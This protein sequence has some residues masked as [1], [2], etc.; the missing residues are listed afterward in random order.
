VLSVKWNQ[1]GVGDTSKR[2]TTDEWGCVW[3]RSEVDNMGQVT[4]HPLSEW[5]SLAAFRWPDHEDPAFYTGMDQRFEGSEGKYVLTPIFMLLFER[6]QAL[7]GFENTMY[8]L[9]LEREQIERLADRIV[10][11]DLGIIENLGRRF[12]DQIH[13]LKF[14]DDWGTQQALMIK[15]EL[16]EAFFR[17]RYQRV[18]HAIHAQGWHV[19]MHSCGRINAIIDRLIEIG[20]NVLNLQQPRVL[21]IE[22]VGRQFAGRVC[23]ESLCDIQR[24]LP[25]KGEAA[26]REEAQLLLQRWGTPQGGFILSDYGEGQAIGVDLATKEIMLDAFRAADPWQKEGKQRRPNTR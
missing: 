3:E 4:G 20:V 26:I 1:I 13:G 23:F 7:R 6:L 2:R 25:S 24:T 12:G 14:T 21:G 10:E 22:E 15:P 16:W 19:W 8:D 11:F 17:P 18:F 9:V 5:S